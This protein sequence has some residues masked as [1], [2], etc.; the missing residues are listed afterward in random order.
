MPRSASKGSLPVYLQISERLIREI[1]AGRL[2]DGERLAPEREMAASLSI[3]VGTLRKALAEL[4]KKGLLERRHGS[5]N[6]VR[7]SGR[8]E[9]VYAFFR[10]ELIE[11]GGLPT[12]ELIDLRRMPK[13]DDVPAFGVSPDAHRIRR[14]RSLDGIPSVLEEIWL[15]GSYAEALD[16]DDMSE[17]LYLYYRQAFD[18]AITRAQDSVGVAPAPDWAPDQFP[19]QPG[20]ACGFIERLSRAQD[21]KI[22]EVS[23]NWF[24]ANTVRYVSRMR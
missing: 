19:P 22:A 12:A 3:S 8:A 24:D 15:D 16:P 4:E 20:T 13:P 14:L 1:G 17:S 9:G 7:A 11:G 5:G 6:Y 2:P 18:L 23:R 21:N 10:I